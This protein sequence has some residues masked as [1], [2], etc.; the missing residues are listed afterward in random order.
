LRGRVAPERKSCGSPS[1]TL[2]PVIGF[3]PARFMQWQFRGE[4]DMRR[5][6]V[7]AFMAM[8]LL[9]FSAVAQ[10]PRGG[11]GVGMAPIA[12]SPMVEIKGKVS[13]VRISPGKGTPSVTV[14]TGSEEQEIWLGSMRYLMAQDFNPKVDDEIVVKAYK[15]P[16][17][18]I[19]A[20]VTLGNKTVRLRD[21]QGRPMWRGGPR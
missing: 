20:T 2:K 15:A 12:G 7:A 21:D 1:T 5:I 8:A 9:T 10:G 17:G 13:K 14:R 19:A 4:T 6:L 3:E 11:R 18:L 16:N